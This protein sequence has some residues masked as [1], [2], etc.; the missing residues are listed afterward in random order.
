MAASSSYFTVIYFLVLGYIIV[1]SH[2]TNSSQRLLKLFRQVLLHGRMFI[3]PVLLVFS[4]IEFSYSFLNVNLMLLLRLTS[5]A[6][7][8]SIKF[9]YVVYIAKGQA[10]PTFLVLPVL[11]LL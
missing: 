10:S 5:T 4:K 8:G 1:N 11:F 3:S 7:D 2:M 9:K 6:L